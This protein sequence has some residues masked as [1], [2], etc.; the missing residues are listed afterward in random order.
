MGGGGIVK[1]GEQRYAKVGDAAVTKATGRGWKEWFALLDKAGA[2]KLDHK[3]IVAL[4]Y[5]KHLKLG[6]WCQMITVGYEQARGLRDQHQKPDGYSVSGSKTL[7]VPVA[8]A[9]AA[10]ASLPARRRWLGKDAGFLVRKATRNKSLR[11]TWPAAPREKH[12]PT[13]V[14]V[15]FYSKGTGGTGRSPRCMVQLQHDKLPDAK[16]A[17]RRKVYWKI[18]LARL[19]AALQKR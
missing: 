1:N 8:E 17:A 10:W 12:G 5:P 3:G 2:K 19:A 4:L 13:S 14:S 15:N 18:A 16:S 6:W 7:D 11:I 9:Y